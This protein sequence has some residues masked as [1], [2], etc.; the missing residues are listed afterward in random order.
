MR[1]Q[2][3]LSGLTPHEFIY[4]IW[5]SERDG[6]ILYSIQECRWDYV[7]DGPVETREGQSGYRTPEMPARISGADDKTHAPSQP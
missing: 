4:K 3:A 5:T 2:K 7:H 6:F 1:R